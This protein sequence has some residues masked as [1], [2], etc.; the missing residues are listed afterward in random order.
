MPAT[1]APQNDY[2][3]IRVNY[4]DDGYL[5]GYLAAPLNG[6]G[7]YSVVQG[8]GIANA[9]KV[10]RPPA[11][12]GP[13]ASLISPEQRTGGMA[14]IGA[15][16]SLL[17]LVGSGPGYRVVDADAPPQRHGGTTPTPPNSVTTIITLP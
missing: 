16:R 14:Y 12:S 7:S 3:Y 17:S 4:A 5:L 10:T 13:S 8:A 6:G 11:G 15:S 2:Q 1:V 9:L